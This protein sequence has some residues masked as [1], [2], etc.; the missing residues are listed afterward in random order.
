MQ[1][2]PLSSARVNWSVLLLLLIYISSCVDR[3]VMNIIA[4]LIKHDLH[5]S[6]LQ[7]GLMSGLAFAIF[8]ATLG[9]PIA[10][11]AE[12][13][14][15]PVI[16]GM[17][18]ATWSLFTILCGAAANVWQLALF[19]VGVGVGEAGSLP[20]SHSLIIDMVPKGRRSTAIAILSMGAPLG[21]LVGM[22]VG[23]LIAENYGWR[24]AF[25]LAG[26]PGLLL[27][28]L[29]FKT[30]PEPRTFVPDKGR[31]QGVPF[32]QAM[33][34]LLAKKTFWI[35]AFAASLKAFLL[36][37]QAPFIASF[38]LRAHKTEIAAVASSFGLG[39]IAFLGLVFGLSTGIAGA[40]SS[41]FGGWLSDRL[42]RTDDRNLFIAPAVAVLASVPCLILAFTCKSAVLA[43]WILILPALLNYI[44]YGPVFAAMQSIVPFHMR[45]TVVAVLMLI[46][47]T[48]GLGLGPAVVGAL[49]DF[50]SLQLGY[51]A[52]EGIRWSLVWVSLA[53][54]VS[55]GLFWAARFTLPQ[56]Y[57]PGHHT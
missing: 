47:N 18:I 53:G 42:S 37:G 16:I 54:L 29:A 45:A 13:R 10:R 14:N 22:A 44:W 27:A 32:L 41:L 21:V 30:L 26:L 48:F 36:Y 50:F 9:I 8:Y 7:L 51:G 43:L 39:P 17:A 5:L 12:R 28:P 57:E 25:V 33:K 11:V 52:A 1:R 49:S 40:L 56:D 23:G 2:E 20:A 34:I 6:D 24:L 38:F 35:L 4:E 31:A 46:V 15:R 55:A 19:R 3:Q